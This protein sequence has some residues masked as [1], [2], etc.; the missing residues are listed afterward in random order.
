MYPPVGTSRCPPLPSS[1]SRPR[2][3]PTFVGTMGFYDSSCPSRRSSVSLDHAVPP[4]GG[5]EEVFPRSWGIPLRAC[6][7]L[8]TP[9]ARREPRIAVLA[10]L[11]SVEE[12]TSAS[13]TLDDFGAES[14]RPAPLLS[15]LHLAG[16]PTQAQDSLPACPL[17]RWPGWI[18]TSWIPFRGFTC[19]SRS[20][21]ATLSWRC[22]SCLR[23]FV[24]GP[25]MSSRNYS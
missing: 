5:D 17:R 24:A 7:G 9:A 18:C 23:V 15:T 3:F 21:P 16:R 1:G 14:A 10:L 11:P 8:G 19:S 4:P 2:Q 6:P 13:A 20:P 25:H 12:T 22:S